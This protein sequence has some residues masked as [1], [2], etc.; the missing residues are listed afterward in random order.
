MRS[1]PHSNMSKGFT[2]LEVIIALGIIGLGLIGVLTLVNF[3]IS[4]GAVSASKLI[5][6]NLAQE[7]IEV[8]RNSRDSSAN[9][10]DW[11]KS[12]SDGS[13]RASLNLANYKWLMIAEADPHQTKLRF[14]SNTGLYFYAP[15][16]QGSL[17]LFSRAVTIVSGPNEEKQLMS[18]V[19]WQERGRN[20]SL[21][22]T[23]Y[24]YNWQ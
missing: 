12:I 16:S 6:A 10:A 23:S 8:I 14:D 5:A 11:Y 7:G 21:K 4:S 19:R 2:L 1:G 15:V 17:T 3:T 24:L 22:V 20:Y 13:Y 18:E 9:W